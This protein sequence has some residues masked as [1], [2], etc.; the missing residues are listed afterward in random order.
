MIF[1]PLALL[2]SFGGVLYGVGA[3]IVSLI[4]LILVGVILMQDSKEGGLGG[5]FGGAGMGGEGL[6]GARGQ[7][8]IAKCTAILAIIFAVLVIAL[9][10]ADT[11]SA[12]TARTLGDAPTDTIGGAPGDESTPPP[13]GDPA[14]PGGA[15]EN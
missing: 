7:K 1:E 9:G 15:N 5:A 4:A 8:D 12:Q 14:P 11:Q 6:L 2:A 13:A 10:W 3:V